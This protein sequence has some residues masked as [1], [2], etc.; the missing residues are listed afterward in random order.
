M[1]N[2]VLVIIY[3]SFF[4]LKLVP[5][6]GSKTDDVMGLSPMHVYLYKNGHKYYIS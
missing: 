4:K 6:K 3:I 5:W 2:D 1:D